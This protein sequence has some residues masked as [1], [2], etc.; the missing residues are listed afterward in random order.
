M[1]RKVQFVRF[2]L[3]C[4]AAA[5][6]GFW[7]PECWIFLAFFPGQAGCF[8]CAGA[9]CARCQTDTTHVEYSLTMAGVLDGS[10]G[11]DCS[12]FNDT[13]VVSF[14][15]G[16][17]NCRWTYVVDPEVC[18]VGEIALFITSNAIPG[19][20]DIEVSF[21]SAVRFV[22]TLAGDFLNRIDCDLSSQSVSVAAN[23]LCDLLTTPATCTVTAL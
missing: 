21:D 14:D 12:F 2:V 3:V 18:S 7:W 17:G 22:E 9:T 15:F 16:T 11:P 20:V 19:F 5:L 23:D 13:F 6:L 1:N 8:C 10:C 4:L